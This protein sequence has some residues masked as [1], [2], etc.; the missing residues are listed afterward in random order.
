MATTRLGLPTITGNMT[1]DVVRDLNALAEAVDENVEER[2]HRGATAPTDTT[3]LWIDTTATPYVFK[4]HN[5][6]S[7][8]EIGKTPPVTSVNGETGAVSLTAADVGAADSESTST[9]L[10]R[11]ATEDTKLRTLNAN[12]QKEVAHL[13]LKQDA[14]ERIENGT[15]FADDFLGNSFGLTFDDVASTGVLV[16]DGALTLNN[17]TESTVTRTDA[18]V[19]ASAYDTSGNGGRK[20]ARLSNG[21][22]VI[23]MKDGT[24]GAYLY[25]STDNGN[26]WSQIAYLFYNIADISIS[27]NGVY[28]FVAFTQ[29]SANVRSYTFDEQGTAIQ[30]S[31]PVDSGQTAVGNIS[32]TINEAGTELHAAWASKNSTYS[33]S[34]NLRYAKG[35]INQSDG[36]VTWSGVTQVSSNNTTGQDRKNPSIILNSNGYPVIVHDYN[37]GTTTNR[38]QTYTYNGSSW[39]LYVVGAIDGYTQSSPSAIFV[40]QSVNGLAN[41]RIWVAWHGKDSSYNNERIRV[42][43]SDDGGVTWSA[44]QL[45]T[46]N[47]QTY[48]EPTLTADK[49]NNIFILTRSYISPNYTITLLKLN[50]SNWTESNIVSAGAGTDDPSSLFD[51]SFSTEFSSPLFIYKH[52]SKVGFYGTWTEQVET[53][54]LTGTAIYDLPST[55][56]VGAFVEKLGDVNV[57]AYINDVLMDESLE[58]DEY[59]FTKSLDIAAPVTL[60]LELNR[61]ST[62]NGDG[63]KVTRLLGGIS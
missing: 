10:Q 50:G 45:A 32:L 40:P 24:S 63:D 2:I 23:A 42:S 57:D 59:M 14:A 17:L 54:T 3:Q 41:G 38:I 51:V 56:Y 26:T 25:K 19:V 30:S 8:V 21:T 11:Q 34:M 62:V 29:N 18:T 52:P 58:G 12:L 6:T 60:R 33:N 9:E 27:T 4:A 36:S 7:W 20:L 47:Q 39:A 22:L 15:T 37:V 13:K 61:T 5:G 35:T 55:D 28:I 48:Q 16:K 1:A 46:P 31:F 49:N 44:M 53:P 43:Y